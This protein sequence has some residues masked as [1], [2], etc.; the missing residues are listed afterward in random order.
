M[1]DAAM[2]TLSPAG[3]SVTLPGRCKCRSLTAVIAKD[4]SLECSVCGARRGL[5]PREADS[6]LRQIIKR[7]GRP[8]VPIKI[9][10]IEHQ[11][12]SESTSGYTPIK[13]SADQ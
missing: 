12:N 5:L 8:T 13:S 10:C 9:R 11:R 3:L 1:T 7:F 4:T 2:I 6:F